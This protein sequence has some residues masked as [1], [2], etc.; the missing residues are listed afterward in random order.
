MAG[1]GEGSS[2]WAVSP[3][4]RTAYLWGLSDVFGLA[5]LGLSPLSFP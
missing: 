3:T 5:A 4:T 2:S 1:L